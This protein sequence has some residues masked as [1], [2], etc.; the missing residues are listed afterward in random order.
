[1]RM[2]RLKMK[3]IHNERL[4]HE[5][6]HTAYNREQDKNRNE[7]KDSHKGMSIKLPTVIAKYNER[8]E[9]A[10]EELVEHVS[11]ALKIMNVHHTLD[12]MEKY[13]YPVIRSTSF[14]TE[15]K[16]GTKLVTKEH[17]AE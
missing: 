12:G 2:T 15:T 6:I 8:G 16:E 1:M 17:T 11:E 7:W 9:V 5:Y 3:K 14:P 4:A 10:L 13:I